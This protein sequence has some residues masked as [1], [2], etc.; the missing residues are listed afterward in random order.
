[1]NINYHTNNSKVSVKIE[2]KDYI[3]YLYMDTFKYY[4][5]K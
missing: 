3:K 5:V 4:D 2:G 1:M